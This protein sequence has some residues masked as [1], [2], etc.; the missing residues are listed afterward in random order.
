MNTVKQSFSWWS[1]DGRGRTPLELLEA[2][3]KIGYA[4]VELI[5]KDLWGM[6]RDA[7]LPI[8]AHQGHSSIDSGLNDPK[9]HDRIAGEIEEALALAVQYSVPNLIVFSGVRREGLTDEEGIE[10]T[11]AGLRRVVRAAGECGVTLLLELLNSRRDHRGY[12]ADRTDWGV[13]VCEAAHSPRIKLLFDI[14]HVQVMEGD[15]IHRI[16]T[17]RAYLGHFHTAGVPGRHDLDDEQ[18][19][20]YPAVVRA[21]AAGGYTGLIGHEFIPKGDPIAALRAAFELCAAAAAA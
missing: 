3:R 18:E 16:E 6:A 13:R 15:L 8:I 5:P 21:I 14:Y 10:H 11:A 20:N 12:Q 19:I 7:G 9:Q 1:F 17:H 2:A 4:G